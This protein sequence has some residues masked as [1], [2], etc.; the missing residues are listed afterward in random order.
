MSN[1][2]SVYILHGLESSAFIMRSFEKAF[3]KAG[4][5][6]HNSTYK[7]NRRHF[8]EVAEEVRKE[9]NS[10]TSRGEKVHFIC[11]SLGGLIIRHCIGKGLDCYIGKI[12]TM[13]SPH[14]GATWVNDIP[15]GR[16]LGYLLFGSD[17]VD[18]LMDTETIRK[19]N[20]LTPYRVLCITTSKKKSLLNPLSWY[21]GKY[22]EGPNDGF[23]PTKGMA[24]ISADT[25]DFKLD[26]L[27]MVWNRKLIDYVVGYV[28]T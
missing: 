13:A 11:H 20:L 16:E 19:M 18:S 10:V 1:Q 7:A 9:I 25:K 15:W 14:Q 12:V 21:A 2:E 6:V 26:H 17:M 27:F 23:V 28:N 5:K 4:Y 3:V 8:G 24:L 22:I